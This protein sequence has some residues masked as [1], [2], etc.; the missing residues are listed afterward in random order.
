LTVVVVGLLTAAL[1]GAGDF[2][3]GLAA[4]RATIL[5]VVAGA[6]A[7]GLIGIVAV[8]VASGSRPQAADLV[9]GAAG[10][11]L[12][13]VGVALLYRRLAAGPM[14]V[15]APLT[16]VTSAVVPM[17]W[18]AA[19]G[20]RLSALAGSGVLLGLV[21]IGLVS[22]SPP[23]GRGQ[24][25]TFQVVAESLAAGAGFGG[26]FIFL[27][28]TDPGAAP[29]PIT[30]ARLLTTTVLV[31]ALLASRQPLAPPEAP[32]RGLVAAAGLLDVGANVGFLYATTHGL[33]TV[34]SVLA[35]LYPVATA[36]LARI[37]LGERLAVLQRL[38]FLV[39]MTATGLIAA[40]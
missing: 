19:T 7:I 28:A 32:V 12:G 34:A 26:F 35:S 5:Q 24:P 23:A 11:L 15:V 37:V 16:G 39:A 40:G 2:C 25:V 27:D 8:S 18:G 14:Q 20:E 38:G 17:L 33:L 10:G 29:W 22:W 30:A 13:G 4:R 21:A 31:V 1:V 3:G 9:L 6:H 36:M